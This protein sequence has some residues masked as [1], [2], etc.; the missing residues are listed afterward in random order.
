MAVVRFA[1][2][3]NPQDL[4]DWMCEHHTSA[5]LVAQ[6][7]KIYQEQ[8]TRAQQYVRD[9]RNIF[10]HGPGVYTD[11]VTGEDSQVYAVAAFLHDGT[12]FGVAAFF[13]VK[14]ELT[15]VREITDQDEMK[16]LSLHS[17]N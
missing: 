4:F 12:H 3:Q 8:S 2:I 7:Y 6:W 17:L 5:E 13:N 14:H 16:N 11:L 9:P 1:D 10:R 15:D